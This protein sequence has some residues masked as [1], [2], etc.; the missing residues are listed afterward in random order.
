[1][2]VGELI[3]EMAANVARLRADMDAARKTVETATEGMRR[4][5]KLAAG[6]LGAIAG[7]LTVTA[8]S[9]WIK[10]AINAADETAKLAQ[11]IGTTTEQVAG[12][13][14]AFRQSGME[15]GAVQGAMAKLSKQIAEG[16][17]ALKAMEISNR[18]ADG[19]L[20][21]TRQALGEVADKFASY[22]D[23]AGKAALAL[24]L[25]GKSGTDMIPLLNGG[26]A[27]LAE[28]DRVASE[29]GLTIDER[30]A[31]SAENFNDTLDLI[32][33]STQGVA[34]RVAADLLPT[35]N[36][37][38]GQF[39]RT[40]TEGDRLKRVAEGI[41]TVMRGLYIAGV[42][43]VEVFKTVGS[44]L[45]GV[46]TAIY[47]ATRG[48]FRA[49]GI[50][51]S[52]M[53]TEIG[54]GWT[55]ALEAMKNAWT[56]SGDAGV[57]AMTKITRAVQTAAPAIV[58]G[59]TEAQKFAEVFAKLRDK[60][61]GKDL[62]VDSD[63]LDNLKVLRAAFEKG[64]IPT[65]EE[66]LR[67]AGAYVNQQKYVTDATKAAA[68][69][70]EARSKAFAASVQAE[71][72]ARM[73]AAKS[74]DAQIAAQRDA[75]EE[76]GLTTEHLAAL[77][78]ARM[79]SALAVDEET[80][81]NL[82]AGGADA[83]RIEALEEQIGLTRELIRLRR[84][85]IAAEAQV[86][87]ARKAADAWKKASDDIERGLTDALF[88]AAES[89]K[90]IFETL[91]DTLRGMFN[92][93][94]L[95]PIISA[96]VGMTGAGSAGSAL[97]GGG[98]PGGVNP[99][100]IAGLAGMS[101]AF[102]SGLTAGIAG[103]AGF[104]GSMTAAGSLL[105]T[106]TAAGGAAGAG[107]AIGA[108]APYAL[109]AIA[110]YKAIRSLTRK[111]T[112]A[113]GIEGTLGGEDGFEGNNFQEYKRRIGGGG[114]RTSAL[115][116]ALA[117]GIADAAVQTRAAVAGYATALGLPVDAL[118]AFT[119][120]LRIDTRGLNEAQIQEKIAEA[121][122]GF[123]DGLA[124][125]FGEALT[126]FAKE[127]ESA[128]ETLTRLSTSLTLVN[129]TLGVLGQT[130]LDVGTAG[131]DAAS[132][133]IEAFGGLE[134]FSDAVSNYIGAFYSET[135][136]VEMAI[137]AVQKALEPLGI[138]LPGTR[139]EFRALVESLDLTT[140]YGRRAY[141]T[142]LQ[143]APQYDIAATA[144]ER[145]A[146]AAMDAADAASRAAIKAAEAQVAEARRVREAWSD[147]GDSL[148]EELRRLRGEITAEPIADFAVLTAQARAGDV[149]AAQRL[150]EAA[151]A[152]IEAARRTSA[153]G[154]DFARARAAVVASLEETAGFAGNFA[155]APLPELP[156]FVASNVAPIVQP[157]QSVGDAS[158][159]AINAV[160]TAFREEVRQLR[161]DLRAA[162]ATIAANTAETARIL[163]RWEG[164]SLPPSYA[165]VNNA[166]G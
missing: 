141:A 33:Q 104:T 99:M 36:A 91:R 52:M 83:A 19:S 150:P 7:G 131:G 137:R 159:T 113:S 116:P 6:A 57:E 160:E 77:R 68:E 133:L 164:D 89:G 92:N 153:S 11:K 23:G 48:E 13:Q 148:L 117:G 70:A 152:V 65:M 128:S 18:N 163:A 30:T 146:Q 126:A 94:V 76:I 37:L 122:K 165:D 14:L 62:G 63:F 144:A 114:R 25:F 102:G 32:G 61:N 86:D 53:K 87:A 154:V 112:T 49:A 34:R 8:F 26:A 28:F 111:R 67:L 145:A 95:R 74:L 21:N 75:N 93:L 80:L 134:Q 24:S 40:L 17:E 51:L 16:G 44:V 166:T 100:G 1:V 22:K 35:L 82:R 81:A 20:K 45:G 110:A 71:D 161:E 162:N 156:A 101:G 15:A 27:A 10:G 123:A 98:G 3:V 127:G 103:G 85:G 124:G 108:V 38:A 72:V 139:A 106:G 142:L 42:G 90:D 78:L 132:Q 120:A 119:Q 60:I 105:G 135:E 107:L 46:A 118:R 55:G 130:L 84:D 149:D 147:V 29:L 158:V 115:D 54:E 151:R 73:D 9:S 39:F 4:A 64:L 79:E 41:S 143:V 66:Y 59:K 31:K 136:R 155:N 121:I 50:A 5:A 140:D 56:V 2:V 58:T 47:L 96:V 69:A 129:S 88:R 157:V 12:L 138:A 97:A 43:V 125:T 109:A